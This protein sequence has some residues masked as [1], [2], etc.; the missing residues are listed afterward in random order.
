MKVSGR[1]AAA[2]AAGSGAVH[3]HG[4]ESPPYSTGRFRLDIAVVEHPGSW[5]PCEGTW[6]G[7][8]APIAGRADAVTLPSGLPPCP[9]C[10]APPCRRPAR[11]SSLSCSPCSASLRGLP[12]RFPRSGRRS[13]PP[14]HRR[15]R[16]CGRRARPAG[17][18]RPRRSRGG[19]A[20]GPGVRTCDDVLDDRQRPASVLTLQEDVAAQVDR[21][22]F[23][24]GRRTA[25]SDARVRSRRLLD[26]AAF[27]ALD[28]VA[29]AILTRAT[30]IRRAASTSGSSPTLSLATGRP[31]HGRA[32]SGGVAGRDAAAAAERGLGRRRRALRRPQLRPRQTRR[33]RV[34]GVRRR[35]DRV[36]E[37]GERSRPRWHAEYTGTT[38]KIATV[39]SGCSSPT[40]A[41]RSVTPST[42]VQR[43]RP[44]AGYG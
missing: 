35:R 4:L 33:H 9:L 30:L 10:C 16:L 25:R 6:T 15:R 43:R 29:H 17:R 5:A 36:R 24:L 14:P 26:V 19:A 37:E 41:S 34:R 32:R 1:R 3:S 20:S 42:P 8:S 40:P 31:H 2:R 22:P 12:A 7:S 18:R 13:G 27:A 21:H 28:T 23:P 11:A 39:G 38:G 44:G